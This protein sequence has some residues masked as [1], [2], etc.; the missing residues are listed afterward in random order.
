MTES[1]KDA[2]LLAQWRLL[3]TWAC[4]LTSFH[5]LVMV[6]SLALHVRVGLGHWPQPLRE[7]YDTVAFRWH[8]SAFVMSALGAAYGAAPLWLL[9]LCFR[10]FR[11]PLRVHRLQMGTYAAGWLLILAFAKIDPFRFVKW[12]L[13]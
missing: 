11:A 5:L 13:D 10:R 3:P 2:G 8:E 1:A 7:G 12:M 4:A 6:L 9:L